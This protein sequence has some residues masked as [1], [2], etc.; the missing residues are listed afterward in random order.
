MAATYTFRLLAAIA[1]CSAA[2]TGAQ[3]RTRSCHPA[4]CNCQH[5]KQPVLVGSA[6][7]TLNLTLQLTTADFLPVSTML[8]AA[9][10]VWVRVVLRSC[11]TSK[12]L[13][14]LLII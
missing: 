10:E 11:H 13:H 14:L 3:N 7:S 8:R 2:V 1:A 9:A 4:H 12:L 6:D 5:L